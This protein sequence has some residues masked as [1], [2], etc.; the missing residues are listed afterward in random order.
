D[1][2]YCHNA[3]LDAEGNLFFASQAGACFSLSAEG[4]LR[5][6]TE[7][8]VPSYSETLLTANGWVLTG[9]DDGHI[10]ALDAASGAPVWSTD[11][12]APVRTSPV[13]TDSGILRVRANDGALYSLW[14]GAP[15]V[16]GD[17]AWPMFRG[18]A[19]R[20]GRSTATIPELE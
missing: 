12:G 8:G 7:L 14:V 2:G 17:K 19:R 20:S 13:L 16:T 11:L 18:D 9:A 6:R 3:A 4:G 5:W 1:A 15:P 10:H